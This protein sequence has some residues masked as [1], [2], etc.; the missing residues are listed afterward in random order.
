MITKTYVVPQQ[1]NIIDM[2]LYIGFNNR[3]QKEIS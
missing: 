1:L 2:I 3:R